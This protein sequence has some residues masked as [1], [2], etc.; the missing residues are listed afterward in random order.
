MVCLPFLLWLCVVT[1]I[2]AFPTA[3]IMEQQ[4]STFNEAIHGEAKPIPQSFVQPMIERA[5]LSTSLPYTQYVT[6]PIQAS[7]PQAKAPKPIKEF[8]FVNAPITV[9]CFGR[10]GNDH[11]LI[12]DIIYIPSFVP[13]VEG[14][15][16]CGE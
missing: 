16:V 4:T 15:W 5:M 11:H 1:C 6:S 10:C 8:K 12:F 3:G 7:F 9:S 2:G 14:V 13:T